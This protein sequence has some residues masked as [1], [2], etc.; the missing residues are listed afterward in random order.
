MPAQPNPLAIA[1]L[2]VGILSVPCVCACYGFPFNVLAIVLGGISVV[3]GSNDPA[4]AGG[5]GM[6]LGGIGLGILSVL[7]G[8]VYFFVAF[9]GGFLGALL[10]EM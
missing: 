3:Q 7:L 6:A 8:A 10:Q 2:V 9:T 4:Q 1:S 5:K